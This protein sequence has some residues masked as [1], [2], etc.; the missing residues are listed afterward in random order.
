MK[1]ANI[2]Y[3]RD[4]ES[5]GPGDAW[6]RV[7]RDA[8]QDGTAVF[9]AC[10]SANQ[11]AK[12]KSVMNEEIGIAVEEYRLRRPGK[13]WLVPVRFDDG[14]IDDWDLG[15]N[16]SLRDINYVDLFGDRYT[17]YCQFLWMREFQATSDPVLA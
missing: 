6:K 13:T 2:A 9:L 10:F 11:R 3:W 17:R 15:A 1:A 16:R 7:I 14:D 5:L 4:R 12:E 8:I